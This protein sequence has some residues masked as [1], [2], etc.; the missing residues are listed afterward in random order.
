LKQEQVLSPADWLQ[1]LD[2]E[3]DVSGSA[4]TCVP[5]PHSLNEVIDTACAGWASCQYLL[6]LQQQQQQHATTAAE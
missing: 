1:N 2:H 4:R 5:S 3:H 6:Y